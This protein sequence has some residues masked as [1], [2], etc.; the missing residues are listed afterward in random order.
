MREAPDA[1]DAFDGKR[2]EQYNRKWVALDDLYRHYNRQVEENVRMLSGQQYSIYHPVLGV[3]IDPTDFMTDE[4]RR[5]RQRPVF[6]RIMP[7]YIITHARMT[8][9]QP[10][11]TFVPGP[12]RIDAELAEVMD[13]AQKTLWREVGMV[14]QL[15]LLAG[16]L[17]VGGRGHLFSRID[18]NKG[19]IKEWRGTAD[20]PIVDAYGDPIPDPSHPTGMAHEPDVKGVPFDQQGNPLARMTPDGMQQTGEPHAEPEGVMKVDV[21][22][23]LQVRGSWGPTPWHEKKVHQI[24]QYLT[25]EEVYDLTG[26]EIAPEIKGGAGNVGELERVLF[27]TG[28]YGAADSKLTPN[29]TSQ[30]STEGYVQV[31]ST[32][33]A[34]CSY[35]GMQETDDS[36]GGRVVMVTKKE[37]L[38][39]APRPAKLQYTSPLR[40]FEFVRMPGRMGTTPQEALNPVQRA[41]NEGYARIQEHVN[42]LSN[43]KTL[44]DSQTKINA[45]AWTNEP[46]QAVKVTRRPNVPAVEYL[47]AP[48]LGEDVYKLQQMLLQELTDLGN[49]HGTQGETPSQDASGELVKELRF[50]SD[51]FLGP[52]LRREVEE[53]GRLVSDW[54][55]LLPL[56]WDDEKIINY[57][58]EDNIA[59]TILVRPYMFERGK[60]NIV[61]DVES[62]LPEGRG[63]RQAKV[64]KMYLDGLLGQP[65][66]PQALSR[67]YE[68]AHFPHLS[69]VAKPGGIDRITAD[70][71]N[72]QLLQGVPPQSIPVYEWYDH[73][74]HLMSLENVMKS[75]EFKKQQPQIKDAFVFHRQAHTMAKQIAMQKNVMLQARMQVQAQGAAMAGA[76]SAGGGGGPAGGQ[77]PDPSQTELRPQPPGQPRGGV[78]GGRMPTAPS[79]APA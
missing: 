79:G 38:I 43:P 40:T 37:C 17:I 23:P 74:V 66:S 78:P 24:M 22:S 25:V 51:R 46:G 63:E 13:I 36:P 69:R 48:P 52:T 45:K 76:A 42:L 31:L 44:I 72:G 26:R 12:D 77:P 49:L 1:P 53:L 54:Q 41:Y 33:E 68:L 19:P 57:A 29:L 20:L 56:M 28:F 35:E 8:E 73:D 21:L 2:V 60:I 47:E 7:W 34:P 6:N 58:G 27:G 39:D 18:T 11:L 4:E 67:F 50:N 62:M 14:D 3:W 10:I 71:E 65:G 15:D 55:M 16:W 9:N 59:R 32:W 5:W 70:Q 30:A 61:P 64:Y 75:P